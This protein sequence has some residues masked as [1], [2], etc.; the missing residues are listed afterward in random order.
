MV[1]TRSYNDTRVNID[2]YFAIFDQTETLPPQPLPRRSQSGF[3]PANSP[4][5]TT[6][7]DPD[8]ETDGP[9][10]TGDGKVFSLKPYIRDPASQPL[11]QPDLT[12]AS[13]A[14]QELQTQLEVLP[15][16]TAVPLSME[17]PNPLLGPADSTGLKSLNPWNR[18]LRMLLP[19]TATL[20]SLSLGLRYTQIGPLSCVQVPGCQGTVHTLATIGERL[21]AW[22]SGPGYSTAS[23][24]D[25]V[26]AAVGVSGS[27]PLAYVEALAQGYQAAHLTQTARTPEQWHT[28]IEHWQA[29][30][31]QLETLTTSDETQDKV[32]AKLTEYRRNL[33]YA[34]GETDPFR[35]AVNVAE[36]AGMLTQTAATSADWNTVISHWRFALRLMAAVPDDSPHLGVAQIKIAEY[37]GNLT[38]ARQQLK[39][40]SERG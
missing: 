27:E 26:A 10:A 40:S 33:A 1:Q 14:L 20:L 6:A 2:R 9:A 15:Q 23:S 37:A 32:A 36:Q 4:E 31:A 35:Q 39:T 30:I 28:V 38:Y 24:A 3:W 7:T 13:R 29:A 19:V 8:A 25:S 21:S 17:F 22:L 34:Q 12:K 16:S 5:S 11:G 18:R